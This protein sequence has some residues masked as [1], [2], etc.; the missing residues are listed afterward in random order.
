MLKAPTGGM[1]SNVNGEFYAGGKFMPET[2]LYCGAI[3]RAKK[4]ATGKGN[5]AEVSVAAGF[6]GYWVSA[7]LA[8]E[9]RSFYLEKKPFT[10]LQEAIA[11]AEAAINARGEAAAARSLAPH[12]TELIVK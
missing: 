8:G 10:D 11:Y 6:K 2:G 7:R 5:W 12:P 3:K 4:H 9:S 1:T